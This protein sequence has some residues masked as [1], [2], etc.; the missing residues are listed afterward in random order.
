MKSKIE[1]RSSPQPQLVNNE[2]ITNDDEKCFIPNPNKKVK[3]VCNDV[4]N[5]RKEITVLV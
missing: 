2:E 4:N 3:T 5:V 1:S